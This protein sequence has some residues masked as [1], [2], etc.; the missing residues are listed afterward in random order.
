MPP[1][2]S[3][4]VSLYVLVYHLN[5]HMILICFVLKYALNPKGYGDKI[6]QEHVYR[7]VQSSQMILIILTH[8][9]ELEDV[10]KHVQKEHFQITKTEFAGTIQT[11]VPMDGVMI[12]II[13]VLIYVLGLTLGIH[14]ATIKLIYALSDVVKVHG[15][16]TIQ[17]LGYVLLFVQVAT[18]M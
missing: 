7:L 10:W 9:M 14:M 18:I 5:G 3:P 11:I 6:L 16:I 4:Y 12:I 15:P 13:V 17:A 1:H 8:S 2:K